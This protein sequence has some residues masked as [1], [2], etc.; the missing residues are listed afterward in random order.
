MTPK[1]RILPRRKEFVVEDLRDEIRRLELRIDLLTEQR[2]NLQKDNERLRRR[3]K[4]LE[5][6]E[7]IKNEGP[8]EEKHRLQQELEGGER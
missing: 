6:G 7:D 2:E 4:Y 1:S 3:N 5:F 8:V